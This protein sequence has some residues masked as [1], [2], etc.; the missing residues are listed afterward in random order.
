VVAC[1]REGSAIF[2]R[3]PWA[4]PFFVSKWIGQEEYERGREHSRLG[5]LLCRV[6]EEKR[7]KEKKR[8]RFGEFVQNSFEFRNVQSFDPKVVMIGSEVFLSG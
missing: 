5:C 7:K 6:G 1:E 8:M 3:L 4:S 2:A